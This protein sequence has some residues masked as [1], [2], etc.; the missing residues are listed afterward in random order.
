MKK[1]KDHF[2]IFQNISHFKI[3]FFLKIVGERKVSDS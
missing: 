2:F 3:K 1:N